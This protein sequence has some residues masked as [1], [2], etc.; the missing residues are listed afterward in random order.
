MRLVLPDRSVSKIFCE[1]CVIFMVKFVV[2][3]LFLVYGCDMFGGH[4]WVCGCHVAFIESINGRVIG[5]CLNG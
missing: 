1:D 5:K 2:L 3:G 4:N